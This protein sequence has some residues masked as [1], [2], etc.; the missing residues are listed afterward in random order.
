MQ[1]HKKNF[2]LQVKRLKDQLETKKPKNSVG[3]SSSPDGDV[4]ENGADSN[5]MDLQSKNIVC[6][7]RE[8]RM[9]M[10]RHMLV[11]NK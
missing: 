1:S 9:E 11:L 3:D 8:Q 10:Y 5:I 6:S 4:Q 7:V 2:F